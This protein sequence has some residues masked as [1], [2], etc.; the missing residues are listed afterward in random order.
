MKNEIYLIPDDASY[1][2]YYNK[3]ETIIKKLKDLNVN[4]RSQ[5]NDKINIIKK[6]YLYFNG[7]CFSYKDV[8]P[9]YHEYAPN[10][11]RYHY[12]IENKT[13]VYIDIYSEVLALTDDALRSFAELVNSNIHHNLSDS[14]NILK[15][16]ENYLNEINKFLDDKGNF[17]DSVS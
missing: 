10:T 3:Y 5:T 11:L 8:I 12:G 6:Y 2:K 13:G 15:K 1:K 17:K 9:E 16:I 4:C 14:K 7:D